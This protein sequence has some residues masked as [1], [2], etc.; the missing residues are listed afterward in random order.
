MY[1]TYA[2]LRDERGMNDFQVCKETGI[3][4]STLS[5]WKAGLYTPKVNKLLLIARLFGVTVSDLLED[6]DAVPKA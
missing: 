5:S 4:T 6:A 2:R 3:A 1:E